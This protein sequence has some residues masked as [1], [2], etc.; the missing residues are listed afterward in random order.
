MKENEVGTHPPLYILEKPQKP[1]DE[2]KLSVVYLSRNK[3]Y[4][5]L[6]DTANEPKYTCWD[7]F[8]YKFKSD[9]TLSIEDKW[10]LVRQLR[11]ISLVQLP[12][13]DESGDFFK[14]LRLPSLEET[15]H[16]V[17]MFV[18]GGM[19]NLHKTASRVDKNKYIHRGIIEEAIASSQLEGAHTTRKAAKELLFNKREPKNE[20]E[21][22]IVNNYKTMSAI[23]E[24]FCK[25]A[26]S[27]DLLFEM[28]TMLTESTLPKSSQNR[29]RK[30]TDEIVIQGQIGQEVYITHVPPSENFLKN[31][32]DDLISYAND[33]SKFVHPVVKAIFLHFWI[34]YLHPFTDGNGRLAR[35]I[36]YW[37]LL[38]KGYESFMYVP[39]ST[40]IKKAPI[41]YAMA[42]IQSEQDSLDVTYF[43]DFHLKKIVQSIEDFRQYVE[44]KSFEQK[45]IDSVI[46]KK[47]T[48]NE[49]QKQVI[50]YL[51]SD[52][53]ASTSAESHTLLHG[54]SRQTAT[55]DLRQLEKYS[56]I[57]PKRNGKYV[58]YF[59]TEKLINEIS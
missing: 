37:F 32:I 47:Y 49:R 30:D 17:D 51:V 8:K 55:R 34:G 20:S 58:K 31:S 38:R 53:G 19:Y 13:Q 5:D 36:F 2:S 25:S 9:D 16:N 15:L 46:H 52:A 35:G 48:L 26:L 3:E 54:I 27:K 21:Q 39:I 18:G 6:F 50:Q 56:F 7:V 59:A 12:I 11:N 28:H 29:L 14:W 4:K 1:I 42:Y 45:N 33:D 57:K 40:I 24:N 23:S 44:E 10:Y 41:Q 22:M 43:L